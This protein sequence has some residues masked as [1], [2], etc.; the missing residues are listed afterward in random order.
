MS[1]PYVFCLLNWATTVAFV[2]FL[3]GRQRVTWDKAA[4]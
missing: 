4:G 2:R 1:V 3:T